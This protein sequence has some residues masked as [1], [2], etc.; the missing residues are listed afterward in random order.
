MTTLNTDP[1]GHLEWS[2]VTAPSGKTYQTASAAM[3]QSLLDSLQDGGKPPIENHGTASD[4][5]LKVKWPVGHG[6]ATIKTSTT[7]YDEAGISQY[8]LSEQTGWI[9]IWKYVL[10]IENNVNYTYE[11]TDESGDTYG[12]TTMVSGWHY[13]RYNSDQPT[14]VRVKNKGSKATELIG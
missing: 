11:F 10:E 6:T 13:V 12:L 14:I 7:V 5:N 8:K 2:T 1:L 9:V 4:F 3:Q